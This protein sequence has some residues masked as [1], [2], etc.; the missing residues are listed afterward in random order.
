LNFPNLIAPLS[1]KNMANSL[2][3]STAKFTELDLF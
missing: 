1:C 3:K 2:T